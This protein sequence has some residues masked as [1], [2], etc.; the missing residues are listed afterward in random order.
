VLD[1][2]RQLEGVTLAIAAERAEQNQSQ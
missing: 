2:L 1:R